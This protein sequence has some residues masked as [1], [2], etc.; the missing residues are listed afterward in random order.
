MFGDI[1]ALGTVVSNTVIIA[2]I[3]LILSLVDSSLKT[4]LNKKSCLVSSKQFM[5]ADVVVTSA[6]GDVS[7]PQVTCLP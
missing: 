6:G 7:L 3:C 5:W 4:T 2:F 1:N